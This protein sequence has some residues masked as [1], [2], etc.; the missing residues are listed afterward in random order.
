MVIDVNCYDSVNYS[1]E[2]ARGKSI[3]K[4][5]DLSWIRY[6][7]QEAATL[8]SIAMFLGMLMIWATIR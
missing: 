7:L 1:L 4:K 6:F 5:N 3:M 8:V 2:L